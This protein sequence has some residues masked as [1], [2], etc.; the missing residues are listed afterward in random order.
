VIAVSSVA[1][2]A[3][4][5]LAVNLAGSDSTDSQ[6]SSDDTVVMGGDATTAPP[7][8]PGPGA[9][10]SPLLLPGQEGELMP[11]GTIR[12][13]PRAQPDDMWFGRP[14]R[15][16]DGRTVTLS[17]RHVAP[18]VAPSEDGLFG[19][20]TEFVLAVFDEAG[21]LLGEH[22][23]R[24]VG[25]RVNLVG[26]HDGQVVV[27]RTRS[28]G[29]GSGRMLP[30]VEVSAIDPDTFEETTLTT[31][32]A[33]ESLGSVAGGRLVLAH[34][35]SMGAGD[36]A[37][38]P[39]KCQLSIVDLAS[40]DARRADLTSC[41]GLHD[42]ALSPNGRYAAL[43]V[44]PAPDGQRGTLGALQIVDLET[45]KTVG[46]APLV[47]PCD[48]LRPQQICSVSSNQIITWDD[49]DTVIAVVESSEGMPSGTTR[50]LVTLDVD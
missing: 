23:I 33:G 47:T 2:A 14:V 45:D 5:V 41:S 36:G 15:L 1:A 30:D 20:E 43:I 16:D 10:T 28:A 44:D 50:R 9:A 3:T 4:A 37:A 31:V 49:D 22:D 8:E 19:D 6:D 38:G 17:T 29:P 21:A 39:T 26:E 34:D 7:S 27:T 48:D 35:T 40:K 12:E 24:E 18:E 13:L 42:V 46:T 11:D 25:G 32:N